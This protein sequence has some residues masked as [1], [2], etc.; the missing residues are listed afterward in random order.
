[1]G[2]F[3]TD[4]SSVRVDLFKPSGKW[5]ET[6]AIKGANYRGCIHKSVKEAT[7]KVT[8]G[9]YIG[10]TAVCLEPYHELSHPIS[11]IVE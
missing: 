2:N 4:E 9:R 3:S 7:L 11:F 1:M 10:C 8:N 5:V 6:I